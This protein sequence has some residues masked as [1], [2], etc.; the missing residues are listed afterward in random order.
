MSFDLILSKNWE[1]T[2]KPLLATGLKALLPC[3]I[4]T[5]VCHILKT[6]L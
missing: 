1:N 2:T 3:H 4:L 6:A 5:T